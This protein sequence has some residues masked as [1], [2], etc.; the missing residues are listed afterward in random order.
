[1]QAVEDDD[2]E[3]GRLA[4]SA[5]ARSVVQRD[6]LRMGGAAAAAEVG[7]TLAQAVALGQSS[8]PQ[9]R[10]AAMRLL[11]AAA[12]AVQMAMATPPPDPRWGQVR[13]R[14]CVYPSTPLLVCHFRREA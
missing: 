2:D 10:V 11:A 9:Q 12:A 13:V 4:G 3:G 14:V 8:V 6:V 5:A 1:M 7:Y